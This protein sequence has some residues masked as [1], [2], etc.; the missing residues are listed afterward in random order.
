MNENELGLIPVSEAGAEIG[1]SDLE[2]MAKKWNLSG[3]MPE[4]GSEAMDSLIE[5]CKKLSAST[6]AGDGAKA[7]SA[8]NE[9]RIMFIN[10]DDENLKGFAMEVAESF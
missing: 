6:A 8:M 10:P 1:K 4:D 3:G 9:L 2:P 5:A 7:E